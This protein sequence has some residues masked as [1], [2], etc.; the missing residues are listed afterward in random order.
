MKDQMKILM[1]ANQARLDKRYEDAK[2][3]FI[4]YLND[5]SDDADVMWMLS[6]VIYELAFRKTDHMVELL[7]DGVNWIEKAIELEP[8][9]AEF[10]VTLGKIL[11]TGVEVPDYQQAAQYY[12][13]ALKLNSTLFDAGIGLTFL[14]HVPE[15]TV[16]LTEAITVMEKILEVHPDN[17]HVFM[18][19]VQLGLNE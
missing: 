18:S 9:R 5:Y 19:L 11:T 1:K 14:V 7:E 12:R 10:Y 6:Q 15:S 17:Q 2:R 13:R 3:L 4:N 8:E 16:S